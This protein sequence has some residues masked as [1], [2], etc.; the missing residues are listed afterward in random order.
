M[1]ILVGTLYTIENE[2]EE[3]CRSIEAQ[4][5]DNYE[6]LV[7]RNLP[8]QEA[9][10]KLFRTFMK[11]ADS[12]D[13]LIKIDA[14]MVI[15]DVEFLE[16]VVNKFQNDP[17]LDLL[18]IAIHDFFTDDMLIGINIFRNTV[19]W[20]LGKEA[21]FT[22]RTYDY[23]SIRKKEKDYTEIA[24]A[25]VHCHNP[26][27]FQAFHYGFH[28]GMKVMD[29]KRFLGDLEPVIEHYRRTRDDRLAYALMGANTAFTNRFTVDHISYNDDSLLNYFN[30]RY[31]SLQPS[32]L[33]RK[34]LCSKIYFLYQLPVYRMM[35]NKYHAYMKQLTR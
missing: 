30:K 8:K 22:D 31:A 7:I 18:L 9:H 25:A 4:S 14:D 32:E 2:F 11:N 17:E 19:R 29:R 26:G 20:N 13:L 24:P 34:A 33:H 12:Y 23:K 10:E 35:V 27:P 15:T 6:H 16:K 21:L 28:R 5:Y 1:R 3:C